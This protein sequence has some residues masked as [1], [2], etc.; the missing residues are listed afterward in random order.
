VQ[1]VLHSVL[2]DQREQQLKNT[3]HKNHEKSPLKQH[4]FVFLVNLLSDV[5]ESL[6]IGASLGAKSFYFVPEFEFCSI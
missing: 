4:K 3:I 2:Q 5:A 6:S 1:N